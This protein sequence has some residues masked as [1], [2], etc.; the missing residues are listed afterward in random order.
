MRK[1]ARDNIKGLSVVVPVTLYYLLFT[2]VP[3]VMLFSY[4]FTN[5]NIV[6]GKND[7]TWFENYVR[8][9]TT[10]EYF[11]SI[12]ITLIIAVLTMIIGMVTGFILAYL[13]NKLA[14]GKG[15]LRTIWYIPALISM[16]VIST[17]INIM[18]GPEG[19][20][21]KIFEFLGL[22][23]QSWY[24]SV[25]WMYFWII[26]IVAWKGLGGTALLFIAGLNGIDR[27]VL[28]AADIDGCTGIRR[29]L[30]VT[31]P[32]MRPML[33]YILITGFIGAFNIFEPVLMISE[34]GPDGLTKVILYRIWDQAFQNNNL[35]FA[36][37]LSVIVFFIVLALTFVNMKI[38][39]D[40]MFR[41][42][43][44]V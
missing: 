8:A 33:G 23:T 42:K 22:G 17:L 34:G 37:A 4:S 44:K 20:M 28:E 10:P 18:L 2:L 21:N 38:T 15:L 35:G 1:K 43:K 39:D 13:L 7:I 6:A 31:L 27:S 5:Y 30:H 3:L 36:S 41:S 14:F 12:L 16:A 40:S 24:D 25:F 26:A 19:T 32:M 29:I 11:Q 9:F